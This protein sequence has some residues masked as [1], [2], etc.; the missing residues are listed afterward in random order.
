MAGGVKGRLVRLLMM[1]ALQ[2]TTRLLSLLPAGGGVD[3][4]RPFVA[5]LAGTQESEA[6]QGSRRRFGAT[7]Q[8]EETN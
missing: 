8:N 2:L 6:G 4:A 7:A 1:A 3:D 5:Y